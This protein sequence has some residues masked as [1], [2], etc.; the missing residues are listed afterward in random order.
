V[1]VFVI[2]HECAGRPEYEDCNRKVRRQIM[3]SCS[4]PKGKR[5]VSYDEKPNVSLGARMTSTQ[6]SSLLGK[7]LGVPG[8]W[9][10][11]GIHEDNRY[12]KR[13]SQTIRQLMLE[14]CL[15][16]CSP[17]RFLGWC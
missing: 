16:N 10:E 5:S 17:D 12:S 1:I 7:L 4:N 3:E 15:D 9:L 8:D 13:S 11:E 2:L 6:S 14:C